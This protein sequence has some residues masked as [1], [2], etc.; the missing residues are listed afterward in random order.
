MC[1]RRRGAIA[2][3]FVFIVTIVFVRPARAAQTGP[4]YWVC[5]YDTRTKPTSILYVSDVTGPYGQRMQNNYTSTVLANEFTQFLNTTYKIAVATHCTGYESVAKAQDAIKKQI[6]YA[7]AAKLVETHWKSSAPVEAAAPEGGG[8]AQPAAGVPSALQGYCFAYTSQNFFVTKPFLYGRENGE[9]VDQEF[10]AFLVKTY[11]VPA[12][13]SS[14]CAALRDQ[15]RVANARQNEIS[16]SKRMPR[17]QMVELDWAPAPK[18]APP[19]PTPAPASTRQ[20]PPAK[21]TPPPTSTAAPARSTG[22][23]PSA[24]AAT[25]PASPAPAAMMYSD[26]LRVRNS[27]GSGRPIRPALLCQSAVSGRGFWRSQ[28]GIREVP[29]RRARRRK[30]QRLVSE[31][32]VS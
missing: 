7:P 24:P 3:L 14:R 26:L 2:F 29:R 20:P 28:P 23:K 6:E 12:G 27:G 19:A 22:A 10:S 25:A 8:N 13:T 17:L 31:P 11:G 30:N 5:S 4:M 21:P 32:R 15:Q 18:A 16:D 9:G 1:L